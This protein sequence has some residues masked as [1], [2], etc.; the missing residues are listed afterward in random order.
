MGGNIWPSDIPKRK[1][2]ILDT[3]RKKDLTRGR[4]LGLYGLVSP[5]WLRFQSVVV[6]IR[7]R[8]LNILDW[9]VFSPV[10]NIGS[11]II[12]IGLVKRPFVCSFLCLLLLLLFM[13]SKCRWFV[14][15]R[16]VGLSHFISG[17]A[18]LGTFISL[19]FI[20]LQ[21]FRRKKWDNKG[22]RLSSMESFLT[23]QG[24]LTERQ[25]ICLTTGQVFRN[26]FR[27]V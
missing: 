5:Q 11:D 22:T 26:Y 17:E 23:K 8:Q 4:D 18:Q 9:K 27:L 20:G 3:L 2:F 6:W 12:Y 13:S 7:I 10:S 1:Q 15:P 21:L 19:D 14:F 24:Y 16:S 25:S